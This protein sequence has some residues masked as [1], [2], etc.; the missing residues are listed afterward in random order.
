M[1]QQ[2]VMNF[3]ETWA[4]NKLQT[5]IGAQAPVVQAAEE[6]SLHVLED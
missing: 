1:L 6:S 3:L 5:N 2:Q 4:D